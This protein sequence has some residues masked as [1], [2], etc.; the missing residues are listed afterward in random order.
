[1]S[2]LKEKITVSAVSSITHNKGR[3][4]YY[5]LPLLGAKADCPPQGAQEEVD[6]SPPLK[7]R[8]GLGGVMR[9]ESSNIITPPFLPLSQGEEKL[10]DSISL[11]NILNHGS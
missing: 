6:H 7:V 3:Q 11:F 5:F 10:Q 4:V 9:H 1:V 8:G 2:L